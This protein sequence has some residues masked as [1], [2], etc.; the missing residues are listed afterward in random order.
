MA[1]AFSTNFA[2]PGAS[3]FFQV[4]WKLTRVMKAA[5][6]TYK[7]SGDGTSK[8][9]TG[10]AANDLWGG[11]SNPLND[12]YAGLTHLSDTAAGWW[13]ASGPTTVK[14]SLSANPSGTFLRGETVTQSTSNATGE[15]I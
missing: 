8:D 15:L 3:N 6:W 9:T 1:N 12:T 7:A 2:I 13:V 14:L 11:N 4:I 10:T 5:G